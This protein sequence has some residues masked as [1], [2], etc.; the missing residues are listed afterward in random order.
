MGPIR[1]TLVPFFETSGEEACW[2]GFLKNLKKVLAFQRLFD[3]FA[4][5]FL[6]KGNGRVHGKIRDANI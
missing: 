3:K 6:Q 5:P 4:V 2:Y 1:P